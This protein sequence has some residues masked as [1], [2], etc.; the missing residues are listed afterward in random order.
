[1][2]DAQALFPTGEFAIDTATEVIAIGA[3]GTVNGGFTTKV[4]SGA[5]LVGPDAMHNNPNMILI[6]E[7]ADLSYTYYNVDVTVLP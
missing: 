3:G 7:S 2:G 6:L 1:M 5:A 4:G